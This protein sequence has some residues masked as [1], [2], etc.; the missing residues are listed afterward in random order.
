[1]VNRLGGGSA[2]PGALKSGFSFS[3]SVF[4]TYH[5]RAETASPPNTDL[6][7]AAGE[8]RK[9]EDQVGRPPS[10]RGAL[11]PSPIPS[12]C[13]GAIPSWLIA[14]GRDPIVVD[15][16]PQTPAGFIDPLVVNLSCGRS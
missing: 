9:S 13:I 2:R 8:Y 7:A 14:R 1:M 10:P 12:W 15:L 5:Q 16:P 6:E 3:F 4:L 11:W